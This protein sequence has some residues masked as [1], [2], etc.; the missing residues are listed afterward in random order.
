MEAPVTK[1][2]TQPRE[3]QQEGFFIVLQILKRSSQ[4]VPMFDFV[5]RIVVGNWLSLTDSPRGNLELA[6]FQQFSRL[7][8]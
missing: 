5:N 7:F 4:A 1:I 3:L 2:V 8:T 6:I